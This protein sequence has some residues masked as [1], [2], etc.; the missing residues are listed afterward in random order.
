MNDENLIDFY[1]SLGF[2][3]A[4]IEDGLDA[5]LFELSPDGSYVLITTEDG[6][7]P[8]NL[9]KAV[10]FACYTPEGSFLW[11]ASFKNSYLFKDIW[12]ESSTPEL[13]LNAVRKYRESNEHKL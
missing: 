10:I 9:R 12:S 4:E 11:S 13:K 5:L 2:E 7:I 6:T 1:G 8:E 3:E